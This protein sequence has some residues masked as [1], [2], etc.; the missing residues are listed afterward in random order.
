MTTD[1]HSFFGPQCLSY[2]SHTLHFMFKGW[3]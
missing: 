3:G 1:K 2:H